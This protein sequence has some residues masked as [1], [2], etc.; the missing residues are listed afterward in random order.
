MKRQQFNVYLP[1]ELIT[2]VKHAAI[3]HGVTLSALVEQALREHLAR[4]GDAE[5]EKS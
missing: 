1:P 5:D 3:D 2:A 4:H